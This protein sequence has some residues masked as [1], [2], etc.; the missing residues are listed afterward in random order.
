MDSW[1]PAKLSRRKRS[2]GAGNQPA[3]RQALSRESGRREDRGVCSLPAVGS[4]RPRAVHDLPGVPAR[5]LPERAGPVTPGGIG[6]L[7]WPRSSS[8]RRR[9]PECCSCS[10]P[11]ATTQLLHLGDG[12]SARSGGRRRRRHLGTSIDALRGLLLRSGHWREGWQAAD[13][14]LWRGG[15]ERPPGR[16]APVLLGD[17]ILREED[18]GLELD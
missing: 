1:A 5:S 13:G 6:L 10:D 14:R 16:Q 17:A 2:R 11:E 15:R 4:D 7:R 3:L 8:R 9:A 18:A 12:S